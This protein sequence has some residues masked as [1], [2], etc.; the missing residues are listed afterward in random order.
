VSGRW[1]SSQRRYELPP[2][3]ATEIRPVILER[4]RHRCRWRE[5]GSVCGRPATDVDHIRRGDDHSLSNLQALC[6]D[7][8]AAKSSAE[9]NAARWVEPRQRP[10][11][12]HPG[13]I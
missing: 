12:R 11:E 7:H 4:D 6:G 9:G 2:N 8:H 10:A 13:L 5:H 1:A 3:W